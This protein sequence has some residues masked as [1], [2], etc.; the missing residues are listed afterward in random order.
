M[1]GPIGMPRA[2][3]RARREW[4]WWLE[5]RA[6]G[7]TRLRAG[8]VWRASQRPVYVKHAHRRGAKRIRLRHG[9]HTR[10]RH[11]EG[12]HVAQSHC[13]DLRVW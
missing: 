6:R 9:E 12:A 8:G 11:G 1:S 3:T 2:L 4:G 10:L 13:R 5:V 7:G